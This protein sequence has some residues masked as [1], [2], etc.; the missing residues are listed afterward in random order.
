MEI[1]NKDTGNTI[2]NISYDLNDA[3]KPINMKIKGVNKILSWEGRRLTDIGN[4]I[5]YEYN[6]QGIRTKKETLN[7][8]TTYKL[9][10]NKIISMN[11]QTSNENV[12][13]DF[14]YDAL[15]GYFI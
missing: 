7:E 1:K 2:Q 9:E 4:N 5:H 14:V 10:G 11:K 3:F 13:L 8:V 15:N 12:V 6:S